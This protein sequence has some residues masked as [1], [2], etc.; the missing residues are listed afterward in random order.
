MHFSGTDMRVSERNEKSLPDNIYNNGRRPSESH[1]NCEFAPLALISK[2]GITDCRPSGSE[3]SNISASC[4][5]KNKISGPSR[6]LFCF[7]QAL[8]LKCNFAPRRGGYRPRLYT[9]TTVSLLA[10]V[11]ESGHR[12]WIRSESLN[13][14]FGA[15]CIL[16]VRG[17]RVR[18]AADSFNNHLYS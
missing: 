2:N 5:A 12:N 1:V 9:P 6:T 18:C 8:T 16:M 17:E 7:S 4:G 14:Q 13:I 10:R 15:V 11:W 3:K